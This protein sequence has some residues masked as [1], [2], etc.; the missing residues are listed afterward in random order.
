MAARSRAQK[1]SPQALTRAELYRSDITMLGLVTKGA[2]RGDAQQERAR[3][4]KA[5]QRLAKLSML[6][7]RSGLFAVY[8]RIFCLSL[9]AYGW[10]SR[11]PRKTDSDSLWR[12][13]KKGQKGLYSANTWL[14]AMVHGGLGRLVIAATNLFRVVSVLRSRDRRPGPT[15]PGAL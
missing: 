6:R 2:P 5:K 12:A 7:L 14:R 9:C 4:T 3:L 13:V 10:L 15:G 11:L 8:A 1:E